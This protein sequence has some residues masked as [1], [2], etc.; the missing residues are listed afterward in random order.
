MRPMLN[1]PFFGHAAVLSRSTI[2]FS[3][4]I[5]LSLS[6]CTKTTMVR[7]NPDFASAKQ[8]V[9]TIAILPPDVEFTVLH[10]GKDERDSEKEHDI[11]KELSDAA[12]TLLPEHGYAVNAALLD[13][14][15]GTDR[16][17]TAKYEQLRIAYAGASTT[18][19]AHSAPKEEYGNFRINLGS[20]AR[21]IAAYSGADALMLIHFSDSRPSVGLMIAG[22]TAAVALEVAAGG[23][24]G[25]GGGGNCTIQSALIDGQTGDLLWSNIY[26]PRNDPLFSFRKSVNCRSVSEVMERVLDDLPRRK[27]PL[28]GST[29]QQEKQSERP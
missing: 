25:S 2:L 28:D 16:S 27:A 9:T 6:A 18:L 29:T 24:L 12:T 21:A 23:S 17:L 1:H 3:A 14:L 19:F 20:S 26:E 5:L 15:N 13:K 8:K 11:Q 4:L 10:V 22:I 7:Q